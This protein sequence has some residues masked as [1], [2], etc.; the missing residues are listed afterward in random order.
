MHCISSL[1]SAI[2]TSRK[3]KGKKGKKKKR[4]E[5]S[6][7]QRQNNIGRL[8]D[9]D[10]TLR[11]N[12]PLAAS[13][14]SDTSSC[15]AIPESQT[16]PQDPSFSVLCPLPDMVGCTAISSMQQ[17][18]AYSYA[19]CTAQALICTPSLGVLCVYCTLYSVHGHQHPPPHPTTPLETKLFF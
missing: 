7:L 2:F 15:S 6:H 4:K 5:K 10:P 14:M 13:R 17:E 8:W 9:L 12:L 19:P 18:T 3:R 1:R 16:V 11:L